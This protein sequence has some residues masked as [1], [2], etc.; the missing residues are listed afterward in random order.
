M[1]FL[2]SEQFKLEI[3]WENVVYGEQGACFFTNAYLSGPA[4]Q[5]AQKINNNDN[6]LLDLY[7]QY[8]VLSKGA[9]VL[10]FFWDTVTYS[11]DG[12]KVLL[13]NARIVH[14]EDLTN[15]PKINSSDYIV[16]DTSDHRSDIHQYSMVYK[17]LL[18]KE[19]HERYRF[20]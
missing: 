15:A 5:I 1:S 10:P 11:G 12:K 17:A 9:Y 20:N 7:S 16:I 19:D 13:E 4:L 8:I 6:I 2:I 3:H 14:N 18:I